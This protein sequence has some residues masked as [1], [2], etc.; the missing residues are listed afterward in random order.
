VEGIHPGTVVTLEAH[1]AQARTD[2][3][4]T[5]SPGAAEPVT[6]RI[7]G[8]NTVALTGRVVDSSGAPIAGASV[9][10]RARPPD[11]DGIAE[12]ETVR[13]GDSSAIR[14]DED[15][16]FRTPRQLRRG[17][18]YRAE[19]Q[20]E[21]FMDDI[22]PWFSL[23]PET[24]PSLSDLRLRRVRTVSGR[25]LDRSGRTIPG[26]TVRQSGDGPKPT[27]ALT[28]G[29]GRF[30]LA[31][32]LEGRFFLFVDKP[33]YR[34][35]WRLAG[36]A[37]ADIDLTIDRD[38]EP[39]PKP[40][41][42][43]PTALPRPLE[44]ALLHRLFD[45][46]TELALKSGGASERRSVLTILMRIDPDWALELING[47]GNGLSRDYER[48]ELALLRVAAAPDEAGLLVES[49]ED[50]DVRAWAEVSVAA[51]LPA[52]ERARKLDLLAQALVNA[53]AV[54][55]P[56]NRA[57]KFANIGEGLLDLGEVD[58]AASALRDAQALAKELPK[59]GWAA[60]ARRNVAKGLAPIDLAGGLELLKG[61]EGDREHEAA[62]GQIAHELAGRAPA[63]AE[64]VLGMMRDEWPHFR[65][66]YA[67]RVCYRMAAVDSA[68]A[69]AIVG[70]M[71]DAKAKAR[72]LGVMALAFKSDRA[73]AAGLLREAFAVLEL[74][75]EEGQDMWNGLGTASTAA[76]GLLP[77]AEQVDPRLVPEALG[78]TLALRPPLR[79]P[80]ARD[81]IAALSDAQ[82]AAAVARYDHVAA[83]A[84]LDACAGDLLTQILG[85]TDGHQDF[86]VRLL[87]DA[88]AFV[89]ADRAVELLDRLPEPADRAIS[90]LRNNARLAIVRV[91][92]D[93]SEKR[94]EFIESRL[95]H[96]WPVDSEEYP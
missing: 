38:D 58:R 65:D 28:D 95:L 67:Q 85:A 18:A 14:A 49:I 48:R 84:V 50:P 11:R 12:A 69:R 79:G 59:A 86:Y 9:R 25:A 64:R 17:Y 29:Q 55:D 89:D 20:A 8:A 33:G 62:L 93:S 40:L 52:A 72:S 76:A 83:R 36:P 96:V 26:V 42:Y 80:D 82:V 77:I 78:R 70:R 23:G 46:Y 60:Y 7:R 44:L 27:R 51:E 4:Q 87:F 94:W 30:T 91:L 1:A 35:S 41:R 13:F 74:A 56:T 34:P 63:A 5:A 88:A 3:P 61:M 66:E 21:G 6:L 53:R 39:G 71:N 45:P 15:G 81:G 43:R 32:V 24:V 22:T 75:V 47:G 2:R 92:A 73:V 37:G 68:R 57:L 16:R 90:R 10:L 31:G 19:A 54:P